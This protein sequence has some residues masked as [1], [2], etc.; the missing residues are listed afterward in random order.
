MANKT[1]DQVVGSPEFHA[2]SREDQVSAKQQ[3]FDEVI[4]PQV[5]QSDLES[6]RSEF[7]AD[8]EKPSDQIKLLSKNITSERETQ[9]ALSP[10]AGLPGAAVTATEEAMGGR[11]SGDLDLG[12]KSAQPVAQG[13]ASAITGGNPVAGVMGGTAGR[14]LSE[15]TQILRGDKPADYDSF[16]RETGKGFAESVGG[17]VGARFLM[18]A[19][20]N[21]AL[22]TLLGGSLGAYFG[23][24]AGKAVPIPEDQ[25]KMKGA[26]ETLGKTAGAVAGGVM[27]AMKPQK[28]VELGVRALG[29]V[30]KF[31]AERILR[32]GPQIVLSEEKLDPGFFGKLAGKAVEAFDVIKKDAYDRFKFVAD[33]VKY[34]PKL[35]INVSTITNDLEGELIKRGVLNKVKG[36]VELAEQ[37]FMTGT[38]EMKTLL[39]IYESL[40]GFPSEFAGQVGKFA[41]KTINFKEASQL[42]DFIDDYIPRSAYQNVSEGGPLIG[43]LKHLRGEVSGALKNASP[44][45]KQAFEDYTEFAETRRSILPML[46]T[47]EAAE[48]AFRNFI[49]SAKDLRRQSMEK[50]LSMLPQGK[51]LLDNL[52]DASAA[53]ELFS[54]T[55]KGMKGISSEAV[56]TILRG[57]GQAGA[58]I[59]PVAQAGK[60]VIKTAL[61]AGLASLLGRVS[62]SYGG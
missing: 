45:L 32:R 55:V 34:N 41:R 35:K 52:Y 5:P 16:S 8:L 13:V 61:P 28:V 57:A 27:G 50:M 33:K 25:P 56:S 12:V 29:N 62:D 36:G 18:G 38:P 43:A 40:K 9:S 21:P 54:Q 44:V 31:S 58:A 19:I 3:Y 11:R 48:A 22:R 42:M 6:A 17:E 1:W 7:L 4:A 53:R 51:E 26:V 30:S 14:A 59:Q 60:K 49:S 24:K 20:K 2:L 23:G 10:V 47:D 15:L 39:N 37:S 46:R